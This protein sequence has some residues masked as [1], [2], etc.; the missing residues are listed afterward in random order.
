MAFPAC[1]I[2][3]QKSSCS[4]WKGI[5][6]NIVCACRQTK[7]R[8]ISAGLDVSEDAERDEYQTAMV[9]IGIVRVEA[10]PINISEAEQRA[11]RVF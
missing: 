1:A 7:L 9:R 6:S 5:V 11:L 2:S 3:E 10:I 8:C 4:L